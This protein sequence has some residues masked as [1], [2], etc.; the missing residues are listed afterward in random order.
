[1][2]DTEC[3]S[4]DE[5][6]DYAL[7]CLHPWQID[8]VG[9]HLRA[10]KSCLTSID[11]LN[12]ESDTI[13]GA[14]RRPASDPDLGG[15]AFEKAV[16]DFLAEK[17][18]PK[19]GP[20]LLGPGSLLREYRILEA[21][22][23]GGMGTVYRAVHLRLER[24]VALKVV[25]GNWAGDP[26]MVARFQREMRAAG[27]FRHPHLVHA[28]DAGEVDGI[29]FLVMEYVPG[30]DLAALVRRDGALPVADACEIIRQAAIGLQHAHERGLVHRDV[31]PS[32]LRLTPE[33]EVKIL[34][35]G[36]ALILDDHTSRMDRP[37]ASARLNLTSVSRVVGTNDYM[38]PEQWLN[39]HTV[40][41]RADI[42]SLGCT[43]WFLLIGQPPPTGSVFISVL[44]KNRPDV[45]DPL[46][47]I[48]GSMVAPRVEDRLGSA[49]DVARSLEPLSRGHRL[50]A[51]AAGYN[52][53]HDQPSDTHVIRPKRSSRMKF[54]VGGTVAIA[55]MVVAAVFVP[56]T[57][58][59]GLITVAQPATLP[60]RSAT[61]SPVGVAPEMLPAPRDWMAPKPI[62]A[63]IAR[64]PA[65]DE[66]QRWALHM[67]RPVEQVNSIGMKFALIPPGEVALPGD[68]VLVISKPFELA[69]H[70]TT[71]E[72]FR[73]FADAER[74]RTD[75][76]KAGTG[77]YRFNYPVAKGGKALE[78]SPLW[79][80]RSPG[81]EICD[82]RYPA[83]HLTQADAIA[84]CTWL[85]KKE[86]RL[87]RLPTWAEWQWANAAGALRQ[88]DGAA[89]Q[90]IAVVRRLRKG[91]ICNEPEPVGQKP[92]NAWGLYDM[93]GN[94]EE[95]TLDFP[96]QTQ[97]KPGRNVDPRYN[98]GKSQG[99]MGGSFFSMMIDE[100]AAQGYTSEF[101]S[102]RIGFRVLREP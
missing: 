80:W 54:L 97:K 52:K 19:A 1:M 29:H 49:A 5:L 16:A 86:K 79:I 56:K 13:I 9:R 84:F 60:N 89:L 6:R 102:D 48:L 10:C 21:L 37:G 94:V 93:L 39:S 92:P 33:G 95:W 35:F 43:L 99:T 46:V 53:A 11:R 87:Y 20:P 15:P 34:D 50:D 77:G 65:R 12:L 44:R 7:G 82:D 78:Q 51:F 101:A 75:V 22:G 71:I 85:S 25:R 26:M 73:Q 57:R 3:P 23:E 62:V 2:T 91:Q 4:T 100:P 36:L 81:W 66:Q 18:V 27:L 31:K 58:T 40:D 45:P 61:P 72:Q 17:P 90:S 42:Y 55:A 24:E 98:L 47:E 88:Q 74:Y 8:Q 28:T 96:L 70:E 32:N 76:E 67:Q 69:T 64:T 38:A 30:I 63:P 83:V 59:I 14:L 41:A 68:Y